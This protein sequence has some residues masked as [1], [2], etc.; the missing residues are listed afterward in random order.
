MLRP[1]RT[2]LALFLCVVL[3]LPTTV[4]ADGPEHDQ[5]AAPPEQTAPATGLS[6]TP[7]SVFGV[8]V[9]HLPDT[10]LL[11]EEQLKSLGATW[12]M[13]YVR[14]SAIEPKN[15]PVD[16]YDWTR[17]DE[18]LTELVNTGLQPLLEIQGNP[19][20]A[21][22][23]YRT[24]IN[25]EN[26]GDFEEFV[27]AL[28]SRYSRPPWNIHYYAFFVEPDDWAVKADGSRGGWGGHG[29]EYAEM[30]KRAYRAVHAADPQG[31]VVLGG[32]A[33]ETW[34][35]CD[36]SPCFDLNFLPDIVAAGGAQYIDVLNYHYYDAFKSRYSP[37]NPIGKAR[38][39]LELMPSEDR[40]K[41]IV[42]TEIGTPYWKNTE[43]AAKTR[44]E[45]ARFV[46][47]AFAHLM[48]A[49]AYGI[50]MLA[51]SW[52]LFENYVQTYNT[53]S[54]LVEQHFGLIDEFDQ[55]VAGYRSYSYMASRLRGANY[56]STLNVAGTE[57]YVFTEAD[58]GGT[59]LAW[60]TSAAK[61]I[62]LR[63]PRLYVS[64]KYGVTHTISD[65]DLS[66]LDGS[67]GNIG[68]SLTIDPVYV[69]SVAACGAD[70]DVDLRIS[71]D[72]VMRVAQAWGS[73]TGE[74]GYNRDFDLNGNGE[75]EVE[76]LLISAKD[77]R[78]HCQVLPTPLP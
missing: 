15:V 21:A 65:G 2:T 46:V 66:D 50:N 47:K 49:P 56:A 3:L 39:I 17:T 70:F 59:L 5:Q 12:S 60:A 78:A 55:P 64:D 31:K 37:P 54:G 45:H 76:D 24:V 4:L 32:L 23:A 71:V 35:G 40:N 6:A 28:A 29:A 13:L 20:W 62:S 22:P 14:W 30:L 48:S 57:G 75:I 73:R 27:G 8:Q 10:S 36:P 11:R 53:S 34:A 41:P 33:Y 19:G 18:R 44:E 77:W 26:L 63:G 74:P 1:I 68:I 43:D 9:S 51:G 69:R 42:L 16:L 61:T 7:A 38:K 72:D 52:F 25:P 58:G 67:V